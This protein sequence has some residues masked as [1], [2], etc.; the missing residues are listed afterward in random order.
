MLECSGFAS[1]VNADV[2]RCKDDASESAFY[3]YTFLCQAPCLC[4]DM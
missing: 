2:L 4:S 3:S 1:A